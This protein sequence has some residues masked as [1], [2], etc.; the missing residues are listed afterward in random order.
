[1]VEHDCRIVG[2]NEFPFQSPLCGQ[3]V[4]SFDLATPGARLREP[5]AWGGDEV[6]AI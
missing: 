4:M 2:A 6:R 3:L 1:M 5:A